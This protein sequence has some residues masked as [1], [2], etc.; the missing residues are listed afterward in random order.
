MD[1]EVLINTII[2]CDSDPESQIELLHDFSENIKANKQININ[3]LNK[4]MNFMKYIL[5]K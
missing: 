2:D 4:L 1:L 3:D 5:K